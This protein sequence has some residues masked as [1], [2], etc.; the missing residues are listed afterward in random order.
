MP[1]CGSGVPTGARRLG[2]ARRHPIIEES[3]PPSNAPAHLRAR[4]KRKDGCVGRG[5][6]EDGTLRGLPVRCSATLDGAPA[7]E[8]VK[9]RAEREKL[10][11]RCG[12][13]CDSV[14]I[15]L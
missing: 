2:P 11:Q 1:G 15:G 9:E 3:L 13:S 10:L 4:L 5:L 12:I 14:G 6:P 8:L 7:H